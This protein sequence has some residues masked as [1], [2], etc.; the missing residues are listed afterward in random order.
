MKT[1]KLSDLI[2]KREELFDNA[3]KSGVILEQRK[4]NGKVINKLVLINFDEYEAMK[5][6]VKE[7]LKQLSTMDYK[8]QMEATKNEAK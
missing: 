1:Y 5:N 8:L 4:T 2:H 3:T 7:L 6:A